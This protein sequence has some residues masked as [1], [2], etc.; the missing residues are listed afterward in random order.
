MHK[1]LAVVPFF[2][3]KLKNTGKS[4][5]KMHDLGSSICCCQLKTL[6]GGLWDNPPKFYEY[7]CLYCFQYFDELKLKI[8]TWQM[9]RSLIFS[10][11]KLFVTVKVVLQ[12]KLTIF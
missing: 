11:K 3:N 1:L 8:G 7:E 6:F 12:M 4:K 10:R 2:F 5:D 9:T